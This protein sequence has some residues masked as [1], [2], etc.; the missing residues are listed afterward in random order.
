MLRPIE[1]VED[2][3]RAGRVVVRTFRVVSIEPVADP[4]DGLRG[5]DRT[6]GMRGRTR[7]HD[8]HRLIFRP[9]ER[10]SLVGEE[11]RYVAVEAGDDVPVVFWQRELGETFRG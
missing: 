4:I 1:V 8:A 11:D 2:G 3:L 6:N 9:H 7:E 5:R 10:R